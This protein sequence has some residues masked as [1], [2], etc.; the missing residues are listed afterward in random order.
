[1]NSRQIG[2]RVWSKKYFILMSGLVCGATA[3]AVTLTMPDQYFATATVQY[4]TKI[5]SNVQ[6]YS[7][8]SKQIDKYV[9]T[10][11]ELIRDVRVTGRVVDRLGWANSYELAQQFNAEAAGSGLDFRTWLARGLRNSIVLSY[12]ADS[13]SVQIGY[14][15]YSPAEALEMAG[16]VREEY[17]GYLLDRRQGEADTNAQRI[18]RQ[19]SDLRTRM[20]AL[21]V[22]NADFARKSDIFL[23]TEGNAMVDIQLSDAVRNQDVLSPPRIP[24]VN[25]VNPAVRDL[26]DIEGKIAGLSQTL[27][28]NHPQ[29]LELKRQQAELAKAAAQANIPAPVAPPVEDITAK[30]E[31]DYLRKAGSVATA[32]RYFDELQALRE[33]FEKLTV[34]RESYDLDAQT[35]DAGATATGSPKIKSDLKY[36]D[37]PYA[38]SVGFGF[39]VVFATLLS[40]LTSLMN[41]KVVTPRD[42]EL[43]DVPRLGVA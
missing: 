40:L 2:A 30:I 42:L 32:K 41:L 5:G 8:S 38:T 1:M 21:E 36:P 4:D 31:A 43:L 10:Q 33:Q 39:G 27:G 3:L 23:D 15:G 24:T 6:S 35:T 28:P 19:L 9:Q 14:P 37:R 16:I 12:D 29:L 18:D 26:A 25:A 22:R 13:P 20:K 7:V 17:L 11:A 34:K